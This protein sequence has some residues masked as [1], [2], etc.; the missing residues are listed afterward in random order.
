MDVMVLIGLGAAAGV[1]VLLFVGAKRIRVVRESDEFEFDR[2]RP[3]AR[4]RRSRPFG[5]AAVAS[6]LKDDDRMGDDLPPPIP[7]PLERV[8]AY[9]PPTAPA[10]V[11]TETIPSGRSEPVKHFRKSNDDKARASEEAA[12]MDK[13]EARVEGTG[14]YGRLGEQ[15]TAVLTTAE[16]AA[17]EIRESAGREGEAI[18]LDAEKQ[19]AAARAEAEALRAE[20]D[21]YAAETRRAADAEAAQTRAAAEQQAQAVQAE[22]ERKAK[23]IE[24]EALRR[25]DALRQSAADL[26]KR[27]ADMVTTFRTMTADLEGLLPAEAQRREDGEPRETTD[28]VVD[29]TLEDALKPERAASR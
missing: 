23:E 4:R 20:A 26:E 8:A 16:H 3:F 17:A 6:V 24:A 1:I 27:I 21:S 14:D 22:S 29:D 7:P 5:V 2:P 15:V 9:T 28:V 13:H 19:V 12:S 11:S 25:G 18:R 10:Q